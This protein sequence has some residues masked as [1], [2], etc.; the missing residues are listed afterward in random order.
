MVPSRPRL[1]DADERAGRSP[2]GR[3]AG[4]AVGFAARGGHA[5]PQPGVGRGGHL[6][7]MPPWPPIRGSMDCTPRPAS[8]GCAWETSRPPSATSAPNSAWFL[9]R[10]RHAWDSPT[11]HSR[12]GQ[13]ES[14]L[15]RVAEIWASDPKRLGR[16]T[17]FPRG[18]MPPGTAAELA[19]RLPPAEGGP[20]SFLRAA[21]LAVSGDLGRAEQQRSLL[22]A[23]ID[24]APTPEGGPAGAD[25]LCKAGLYEQCSRILESRRSL[26][27]GELLLLGRAYLESGTRAT[28][29]DRLHACHARGVRAD[30]RGT[31]LDGP[32]PC[33][34]WLTSASSRSRRSIRGPGGCTR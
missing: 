33:S 34:R 15:A 25:E 27:R 24:S 17:D 6:L 19:G 31:V 14:A 10:R 7:P 9:A 28:G 13:V 21:L 3:P 30:A 26:T 22:L 18:R 4:L 32:H 20:A 8:R 29:G 16:V 23:A 11:R 12:G 1:H 5:G 2:R